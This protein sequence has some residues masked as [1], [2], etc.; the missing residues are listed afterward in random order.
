MGTK[1]GGSQLSLETVQRTSKVS[2]VFI[3][4]GPIRGELQVPKSGDVIQQ[5]G[6]TDEVIILLPVSLQ[7]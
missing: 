1:L 2:H 3:E 5:S 7:T 6:D 4:R